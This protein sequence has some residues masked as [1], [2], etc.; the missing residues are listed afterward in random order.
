VLHRTVVCRGGELSRATVRASSSAEYHFSKCAVTA[1]WKAKQA[2]VS[3]T[4]VSLS[5]RD[6]TT[7]S[8]LWAGTEIPKGLW[9]RMEGSNSCHAKTFIVIKVESLSLSHF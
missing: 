3:M 7:S 1:L 4:K 8:I 2:M 9:R 5:D 6:R